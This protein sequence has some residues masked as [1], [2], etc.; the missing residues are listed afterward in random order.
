MFLNFLSY[1]VSISAL[2]YRFSVL[3]SE[4]MIY[5]MSILLNLL[6]LV[7]WPRHDQILQMFHVSLKKKGISYSCCVEWAF[8]VL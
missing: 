3:Y 5:V 4:H 7:L 8:V 6:K 1:G 2:I